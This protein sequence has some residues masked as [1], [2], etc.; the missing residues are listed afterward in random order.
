[1]LLPLFSNP[2]IIEWE[3]ATADF[4]R[5]FYSLGGIVFGA[6]HSPLPIVSIGD[7]DN[8]S[9][10][11]SGYDGNWQYGGVAVPRGQWNLFATV[12]G[13]TLSPAN[14][15]NPI[16]ITNLNP[17]QP[18]SFNFSTRTGQTYTISGNI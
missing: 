16:V 5:P 12:P 18:M 6:P 2:V 15:T 3:D 4:Y 9:H 14:F 8:N 11:Y 10:E 17:D 7:P 13:Y 1:D